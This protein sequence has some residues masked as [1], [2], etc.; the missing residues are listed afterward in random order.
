MYVSGSETTGDLISDTR[1]MVMTME[2]A[3]PPGVDCAGEK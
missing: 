1:P 3:D 2:C